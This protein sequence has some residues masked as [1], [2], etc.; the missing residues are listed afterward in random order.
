MNNI[1]TKCYENPGS[2]SFNCLCS[3]NNINQYVFYTNVPSAKIYKDTEGILNHYSNMLHYVNPDSWIWIFD[4]RN[5][6]LIHSLEIKTAIG[7]TKIV[8]EYGKLHKIFVINS[9]NFVN[10]VYSVVK[11]LLS[12]DIRNKTLFIKSNE[13]NKYKSELDKLNL[14]KENYDKLLNYMD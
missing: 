6:G 5:F 8:T 10:S 13:K 9:N 14:D 12:D 3:T 11:L 4:C 2:H 7:I 1:C